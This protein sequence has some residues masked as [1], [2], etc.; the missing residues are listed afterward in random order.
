L[1]RRI[2]RDRDSVGELVCSPPTIA[3]R[4]AVMNPRKITEQIENLQEWKPLQVEW[5][6]SSKLKREFDP[7]FG[8]KRI[9][10]GNGSRKRTANVLAGRLI[11]KRILQILI[12]DAFWYSFFIV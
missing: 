5:L 10:G 6:E 4:G 1:L 7:T 11:Q 9:S 12:P 8:L 2:I 3:E